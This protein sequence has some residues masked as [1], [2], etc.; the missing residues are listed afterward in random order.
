M[1]FSAFELLTSQMMMEPSLEPEA[2]MAE[3]SFNIIT[4]YNDLDVCLIKL[5]KITYK[6]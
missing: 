2:N 5:E 3:K 4:K 6:D 1:R